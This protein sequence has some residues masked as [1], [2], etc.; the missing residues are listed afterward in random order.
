MWEEA[1]AES[2][3]RPWVSHHHQEKWLRRQLSDDGWED[4]QWHGL[5]QKNPTTP[6]KVSWDLYQILVRKV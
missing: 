6:M 5:T 3:T 2:D 1:K 4:S